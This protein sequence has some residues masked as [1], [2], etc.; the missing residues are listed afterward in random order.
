M[1]SASKPMI[2]GVMMRLL[3]TVWNATVATACATTIAATTSSAIA[4]ATEVVG[5]VASS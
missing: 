3:V 1:Y 5:C 4:V 2:D